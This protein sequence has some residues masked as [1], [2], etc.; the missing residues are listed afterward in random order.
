MNHATIK[1]PGAI[2]D[3]EAI[4]HTH[5]ISKA[6]YAHKIAFLRDQLED[7]YEAE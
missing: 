1:D 7:I 5:W 3:P 6:L 2:K 4:Y